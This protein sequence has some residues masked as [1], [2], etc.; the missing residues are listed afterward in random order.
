MVQMLSWYIYS[1]GFLVYL[2][3]FFHTCNNNE[4]FV[5]WFFHMHHKD[6]LRFSVTCG[7]LVFSVDLML[8]RLRLF[9]GLDAY[10]D[11]LLLSFWYI[12]KDGD[13]SMVWKHVK[14]GSSSA[15]LIH[16]RTELICCFG[17]HHKYHMLLWNIWY[18]ENGLFQWFWY[19]QDKGFSRD[20][21]DSC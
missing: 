4:C 8:F 14:M 17:L 12:Y 7:N 18:I 19:I 2:P 5:L 13:F 10:K 1:K 11:R 9:Y 16:I 15:V 20:G 21:F 6:L 3:C